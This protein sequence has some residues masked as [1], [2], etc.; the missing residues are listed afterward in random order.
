MKANNGSSKDDRKFFICSTN[1]TAQPTS[2]DIAEVTILKSEQF[3]NTYNVDLSAAAPFKQFYIYCKDALGVSEVSV[4]YSSMTY[5]DYCT[6]VAPLSQDVTISAVGYST[7]SSA[8]ALIV[9]ADETVY[10]AK[11]KNETTVELI[12]V[13]KDTV[14]KAGEGFIVK[15]EANS[16]VTFAVSTED[17]DPIEENELLGTGNETLDLEAGEAYLLGAKD[18]KAVFALCNEGTLGANKACLPAPST[19][20]ANSTLGFD[21]AT[22][23]ISVNNDATNNGAIYNLN[24]QKVGAGYKGIVIVNGKK[25]FN[26]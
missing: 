26:K 6:T 8:Y 16:T 7:Y 13:N 5:S 19:V 10:G 21:D 4:T 14:L 2:G 15:G 20:G 23:I 3:K 1:E 11:I 12:P 18:G 25:M 22:G 9:P 17:S 24:G